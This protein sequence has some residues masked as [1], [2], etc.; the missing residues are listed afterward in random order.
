[1]SNSLNHF[2]AFLE[3][4][5]VRSPTGFKG[6]LVG[7]LD[8]PHSSTLACWLGRKMLAPSS[9]RGI[10]QDKKKKK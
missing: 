9:P 10:K 3:E 6:V 5:S 8:L 1:M 2:S 7:R 4:E